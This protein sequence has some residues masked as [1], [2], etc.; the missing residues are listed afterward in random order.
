MP[1]G[2]KQESSAIRKIL[3]HAELGFTLTQNGLALE[4]DSTI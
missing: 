2:W 3:A 1:L 4:I